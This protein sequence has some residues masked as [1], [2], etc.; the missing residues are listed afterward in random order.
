MDHPE[1]MGCIESIG[2]GTRDLEHL[3]HGELL[4]AQN[5]A[6]EVTAID[7][8][9]HD[10]VLAFFLT[11]IINIDNAG[12]TQIGC[13]LGFVAEALQKIQITRMM[14]VQN[15]DGNDPIEAY[16][17]TTVDRGHATITDFFCQLVALIEYF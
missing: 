10:E 8:F 2:N 9:H 4:V 6:F 1:L 16:V 17:T 11:D 7:E 14:W 3:L 13:S 12:M 15:L 5:H